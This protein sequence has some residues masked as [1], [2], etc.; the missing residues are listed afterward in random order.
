M[1]R[2]LVIRLHAARR[3]MERDIGIEEIE[4]VVKSGETIQEWMRDAGLM[5]F[6]RQDVGPHRWILQST[7]PA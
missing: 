1:E 4:H 7:K 6:T 5:V 2:Q 3:M